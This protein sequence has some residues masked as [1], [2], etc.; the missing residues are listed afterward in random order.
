LKISLDWLS[1]FVNLDGL[2]PER[3]ADELT[4][5]TAEVEGFE[6]ERHFVEGVIVGEVVSAERISDKLHAVEVEVGGRRMRS[7]CGAPGVRVGL[8]APFAP[9]GVTLKNGTV[10]A[11]E[12]HGHP[13]EGVLLSAAELGLGTL[14]EDLLT[15]PGSIAIGTKLSSLVPAHD[16]VIEIDNKSLTHRP[17]LWGHYGFARELAAIFDRQLK[18]YEVPDLDRFNDLPEYPVEVQSPDCPYY[19]ATEIAVSDNPPS[20]LMMQRRLHVLG[21]SSIDLLVD[22]TNYVQLELGQPT[23]AFDATKVSRIG[24]RA[25]GSSMKFTTLDGNTVELLPEDLLILDGDRPVALAGI[26]GGSGSEVSPG[27]RKILLESANFKGSRVRLTSV[28]LA[29]RT[30]SSLRFEKKLPPLYAKLAAGRILHWLEK[31]GVNPRPTSRYSAVGDLRDRH[32]HISLRP[33]YVAERAG[34]DIDDGTVARILTSI[35]FGVFGVE[36]KQGLDVAVPPFRG[37]EDI[38]IPEDLSEEVM[39]L[40]GYDRITPRLPAAQ[41]VPAPL[42]PSRSH[43]RMRRILSEG[44]GFIETETY[45]WMADDWIAALGYTPGPTLDIRNPIANNRRRMR[46]TL[47]PNLLYV[48]NQNRKTH[49]QF[50]IYELGRIFRATP[51]AKEEEDE[52][53]GVSVDPGDAES[54]FRRVRAALDDLVSAA[55]LPP[56]EVELAQPKAP[57]MAPRATL[58]LKLRG[59]IVGHLGVLPPALKRHV[60]D[61]GNAVWFSLKVAPL[62]GDLYPSFT[63][64]PPPVY[65]GSWQDF[66]LVWQIERGY[67]ELTA[68]LDEFRH[69]SV[70]RRESIAFYRPKNSATGNYSFRFFLRHL[71]RT[72]SAE[73]IEAFRAAFTEFLSKNQLPLV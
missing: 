63:S 27:T 29:L 64:A 66:T 21:R 5:R 73:D 72:L 55:G 9:A 39:R 68:K 54:H 65:P 28:R 31:A 33:G 48:A 52:L 32:R 14:H 1:D 17:D 37:I 51:G 16:V 25:A 49:E 42:H 19:S 53:S 67:R 59:E 18:P 12:M 56:L 69:A 24:V 8:K 43:H 41:M 35:G 71:D 70:E 20:P 34:A 50:A 10:D 13:S 44:H 4:V 62:I 3:I 46:D 22:V 7:V 45:G 2:E 30:D 26:M 11:R 38:S 61:A 40:Y 6:P 58:A 36:E 60:L 57:W 47:V 15:I 23:H